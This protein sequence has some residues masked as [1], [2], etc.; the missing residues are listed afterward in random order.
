MNKSFPIKKP[1]F[2]DTKEGIDYFTQE[3]LIDQ[4][5][6]KLSE[7]EKQDIYKLNKDMKKSVL[8][9]HIKTLKQFD[10]HDPSTYPSRPEVR[11]KLMEIERLEKDLAPPKLVNLPIV[12]NN[13]NN[14]KPRSRTGNPSGRDYWKETVKL[15]AGNKGPTILPEVSP[16]DR[17]QLTPTKLW[18]EIY[19]DMS[20]FEKGT[21]NAEQRKNKLQ[22][23]KEEAA[24]KKA[25]LA[26]KVKAR[27]KAH[28]SKAW[29]AELDPKKM[30]NQDLK[31]NMKKWIREADSEK[32]KTAYGVKPN[33][34]GSNPNII[35]IGPIP[36]EKPWYEDIK[37]LRAESKEAEDKFKM[38]LVEGALDKLK[39]TGIETILI[40]ESTAVS[41]EPLNLDQILNI[42]RNISR[43]PPKERSL[44]K[45]R[46]IA[47]I[48][49]ARI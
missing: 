17:N 38:V 28:Y 43:I 49:K 44:V 30:H 26:A 35:P 11:G 45:A 19:K 25:E 36:H 18:K 20:P 48:P 27:R 2:Y 21:F 7:K 10:N 37:K 3:L 16:E 47:S 24:E 13:I 33:G 22:R 46:L 42:S 4:N 14:I 5:S 40:P 8:N 32:K 6:K 34:F 39:D 29:G 23:Q 9:H 12:K 41:S 15:N 1:Y 31:N